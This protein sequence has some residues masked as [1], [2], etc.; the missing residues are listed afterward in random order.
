MAELTGGRLFFASLR[1]IFHYLFKRREVFKV[2]FS[3]DRRDTADSLWTVAVMALHN[4]NH[5]FSLQ[6]S[7]MPAQ[8]SVG[9]RTQFFQIIED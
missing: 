1:R 7:Q 5:P 6:N 3:P 4:L 8:I 9:Q 2:P